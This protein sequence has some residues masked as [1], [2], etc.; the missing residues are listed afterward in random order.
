MP[1]VL[2]RVGPDLFY[3]LTTLPALTHSC[4]PTYQQK[5]DFP[6]FPLASPSPQPTLKT[7]QTV[8]VLLGVQHKAFS[9]LVF[10]LSLSLSLSL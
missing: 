6:L 1:T 5:T 3:V 4:K 7:G 8:P 9:R 10:S 2:D